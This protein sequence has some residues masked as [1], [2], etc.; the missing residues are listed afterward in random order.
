[1]E[2]IF[3]LVFT[4]EIILRLKAYNK[5]RRCFFDAWFV[6]DAILVFLTV[7][8]TW[9]TVLL[10]I[11]FQ[12]RNDFGVKPSLLRLFRLLRLTRLSRIIKT[13]PELRFM[14]KGLVQGL[15]AVIGTLVLLVSMLYV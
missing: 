6:F 7:L 4:V 8:D 15:R 9:V 10:A 13:I 5:K 2:N 1:M 11:A 12:R 3:C 14:I